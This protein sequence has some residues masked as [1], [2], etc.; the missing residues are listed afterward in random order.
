MQK[1]TMKIK[2]RNNNSCKMKMYNDCVGWWIVCTVKWLKFNDDDDAYDDDEDDDDY[3]DDDVYG[4][5]LT[6]PSQRTMVALSPYLRV[7][8][9]G[10]WPHRAPPETWARCR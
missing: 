2:S 6:A 5:L 8:S 7:T 3:E 4:A 1:N 10:R 9:R